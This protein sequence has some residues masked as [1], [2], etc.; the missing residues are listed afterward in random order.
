MTTAKASKISNSVQSKIPDF[1][2]L[3]EAAENCNIDRTTKSIPSQTTAK[4]EPKDV[5]DD[6]SPPSPQESQEAPEPV[7][8][9]T[10]CDKD[11]FLAS[12]MLRPWDDP[13]NAR[14]PNIFLSDHHTDTVTPDALDEH[15][16]K[17]SFMFE[18]YGDSS[19]EDAAD[20]FLDFNRFVN[21]MLLVIQLLAVCHAYQSISTFACIF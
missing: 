6:S 9:T 10:S 11:Y 18:G 16:K 5:V 20:S 15:I 4:D 17:I 13:H 19:D 12:D 14:T 3:P 8:S 7:S 1:N 2:K 21:K